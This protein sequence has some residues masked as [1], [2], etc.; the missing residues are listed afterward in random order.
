MSSVNRDVLIKVARIIGGEE[1][2]KVID[3][4]SQAD[5]MTEEDIVAKTGVK[6]NDVRRVLYRLYE[7]SLVGLRRTRDKDTGWFI[8]YWR[9]QTDQI[10]GFLIGQ[11][12]KVLEKLETRL[13]YERNR[14]FYY[15][16]TPGCRRVTF[17]EAT[18]YIFRCP[19]CNKPLTHY[20][21]S[22]IIDA[23]SRKIERI[24]SELNE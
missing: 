12:K 14:D 3:A 1:A 15:C 16:Y 9:V 19:V 6:L 11:K 21:N 8:F 13:E 22:K 23:L 4:L 10:E 7:H 18:E 2:I 24:K 20:D 5:E 17:E